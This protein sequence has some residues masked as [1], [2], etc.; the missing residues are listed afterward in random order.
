MRKVREAEEV[1]EAEGEPSAA[2]GWKE[3]KKRKL[4]EKSDVGLSQNIGYS[5]IWG[6]SVH[7]K[8][9]R[10]DVGAALSNTAGREGMETQRQLKS[11]GRDS[12][13]S[14]SCSVV[15]SCASANSSETAET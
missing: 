14:C 2:L 15:L 6:R 3:K 10:G 13:E 4:Q 5:H 9:R 11:P 1:R 12:M 8:E 7:V